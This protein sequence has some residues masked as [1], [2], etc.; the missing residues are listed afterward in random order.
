MVQDV[1]VAIAVARFNEYVTSQMLERCVARLAEHGIGSDETLIAW[2]PGSFDLPLVAKKMAGRKDIDVVICLGAVIRGETAHF[3]HVA[4][5]AS[6]GITRVALDS[7]KPVIFGVLT[8][9]NA[10]QAVARVGQGA[11]YA[12]AAVEMA[13]L[14][15]CLES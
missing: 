9:D 6:M 12:D 15:R 5:G 10:E 7:G 11:D 2:A 3:D 14:A 8:T 1:K 4:Y 13:E